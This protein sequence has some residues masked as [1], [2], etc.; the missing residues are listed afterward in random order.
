MTEP[1]NARELEKILRQNGCDI[2][3]GKGTHRM[4]TL[5]NG[6]LFPYHVHGEYGKGIRRK[7]AKALAAAGLLTALFAATL[8]ALL[9]AFPI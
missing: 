6:D 2:R 5:P 8:T 1:K 9:A 7:F 4:A 3:N